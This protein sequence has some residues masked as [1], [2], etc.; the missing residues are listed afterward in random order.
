MPTR[1]LYLDGRWHPAV[2]IFDAP[3]LDD[4]EARL[5]G[6]RSMSGGGAVSRD[7]THGQ[8]MTPRLG[9]SGPLTVRDFVRG[10]ARLGG[11]LGCKHDGDPVVKTLWRGYQLRGSPRGKDVGNR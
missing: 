4:L 5:V 10:V 9:L 8:I 2:F 3:W 6:A 11:F 7:I 1:P